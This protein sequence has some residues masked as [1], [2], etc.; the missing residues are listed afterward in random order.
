[1]R[2]FELLYIS[3]ALTALLAAAGCKGG[4]KPVGKVD[5]VA[6]GNTAVVREKGGTQD[7]LA[8][9]PLG[10]VL[11]PGGPTLYGPATEKNR[12]PGEKDE[13]QRIGMKGFCIDKYEFPNQEG[14]APMRSVSWIEAGKLCGEK[15]KKLCTE[16]EF[17]KACRGPS[18]TLYAYGDGFSAQAC[19]TAG[20]EYG[21]GQKA[22]CVSGFGVQDM[23]G[24]VFEWT[25]S[26]QAGAGAG[27][28]FR[29][30]RGG[31]SRDNVPNS[32]RCT[33]RVR[34]N[35]ESSGR[36]IG[37]RCCSSP[38]KEELSK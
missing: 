30:L 4:G 33:Y 26:G 23:S 8:S 35:P 37:F 21:A 22:N 29:I 36:E 17:E 18:G 38:K 15:D 28:E 2:R 7:L 11:V 1:M 16:Y 14:E 10:M 19:P 20:E 27:G 6:K 12:V 5:Y 32:G 9:C 31:L 34:Q 25:S 24:G 3:G 13:P